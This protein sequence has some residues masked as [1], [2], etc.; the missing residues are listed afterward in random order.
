MGCKRQ[1]GARRH[2][3]RGAGGS[4]VDARIGA[5]MAW[6]AFQRSQTFKLSPGNNPH[7]TLG[8]MIPPVISI[9]G[10]TIT[11]YY[12][13]FQLADDEYAVGLMHYGVY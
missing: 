11:W 13:S 4:V 5:G 6:Y 8:Y 2:A 3:A 1:P 10:Q 12:P 7:G 9:S